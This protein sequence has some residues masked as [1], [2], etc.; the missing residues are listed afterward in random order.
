MSS[1]KLTVGL[2]MLSEVRQYEFDSANAILQK[3]LGN[4][5]A[6]PEMER[7]RRIKTSNAKINALLATRGVRATREESAPEE[8]SSEGVR[9]RGS[10]A[11]LRARG[12]GDAAHGPRVAPS[13]AASRS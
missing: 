3:L 13:A 8:T 10:P 7:Y 6:A 4:I 11:G 9:L 2:E 12:R 5:L 1:V